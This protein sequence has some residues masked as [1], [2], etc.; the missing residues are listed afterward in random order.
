[1]P[2]TNACAFQID[3]LFD[4][5]ALAGVENIDPSSAERGRSEMIYVAIERRFLFNI[6][7][8]SR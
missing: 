6:D 3:C 8:S 2:V 1:M 7:L 4:A 5:S